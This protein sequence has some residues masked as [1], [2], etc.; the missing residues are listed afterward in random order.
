MSPILGIFA[1]ST[2]SLG[3]YES[4]QTYALSSSQTTVTFSSI[5]STY[6]H[7]Q[8]RFIA[9]NTG[10]GVDFDYAAIQYNGNNS[11]AS[12][13]YH[14]LSGN[15]A[16][17]SS[18]GNGTGVIG[19]NLGGYIVAGGVTANRFGVG[20]IDILDYANTNKYKTTRVL[21]GWDNNG[22]GNIALISGLFLST[23]AISSIAISSQ[24]GD[25]AQYSSFALY[26]IK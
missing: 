18:G 22:A 2:P 25:L 7:L 1:S 16:S 15:G 13:T 4:I 10:A 6:K 8:I 11:T 21:S 26:G 17:A 14:V 20:V 23:S 9:R 5:P 12:Y 24:T 19:Y 3:D